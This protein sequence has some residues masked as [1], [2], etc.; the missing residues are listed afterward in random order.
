VLCYLEGLTYGAAAQQLELSEDTVRGRLA[1]ARKR[2][3]RRLTLC[4]VTIPAGGQATRI[5]SAAK[6]SDDSPR[7]QSKSPTTVSRLTGVVKL[8]GTD[9]PIAGAKLQISVGFVMGAGSKSE[10]VVETGADGR[11]TVDLPAGNTRI[12]LSDPPPGYLV[13]STQDA[14]EEVAV[15]PDEPVIRKEYRVRKGTIWNFQFS[16]GSHRAPST[17]FLSAVVPAT[18]I[19][20]SADARGR[21]L[22]TLPTEGPADRRRSEPSPQVCARRDRPA[23]WR[24]VLSATGHHR[25]RPRRQDRFPERHFRRPTEPRLRLQTDQRRSNEHERAKDQRAGRAHNCRGARNSPEIRLWMRALIDFAP[26]ASECGSAGALSRHG[27]V[28]SAAQV[29]SFSLSG[30]SGGAPA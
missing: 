7:P 18:P 23:V 29:A 27:R 30:G 14:I 25:D 6:P 5:Q 13:L 22:L 8:D 11:F 4:D 26:Q 9:Q 28:S 2:L 24:P 12:F 21:A 17:G 16:R 3:R 20:A 19:R 15:R 10:K 1:Q